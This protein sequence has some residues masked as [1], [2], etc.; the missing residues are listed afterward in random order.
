MR[1]YWHSD[2]PGLPAQTARVSRREKPRRTRYVRLR[3]A[4]AKACENG[5]FWE[6]RRERAAKVLENGEYR[7]RRR[8]NPVFAKARSMAATRNS[9]SPLREQQ[10]R[11]SKG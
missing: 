1:K 7:R 9:S 10:N 2:V 6:L 11:L 8:P 4:L 3:K 5:G